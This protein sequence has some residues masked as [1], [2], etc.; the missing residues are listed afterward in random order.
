MLRIRRVCFSG[1]DTPVESE[2]RGQQ[3]VPV[4]LFVSSREKLNYCDFVNDL[5][6]MADSLPLSLRQV[7]RQRDRKRATLLFFVP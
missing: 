1:F 2:K 5:Q 7:T 4:L 6:P 3:Y